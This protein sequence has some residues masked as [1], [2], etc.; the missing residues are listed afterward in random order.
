MSRSHEGSSAKPKR[1]LRA[2]IVGLLVDEDGDIKWNIYQATAILAGVLI[3]IFF[4]LQGPN[5]LQSLAIGLLV[6]GAALAA[7]ILI[8][9]LFGIPRTLQREG[10]NGAAGANSTAEAYGVNTTLE[11]I[12]DWLT[13]IIV[14]VGLLPL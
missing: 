3:L 12:S 6:A 14:G 1:S 13:K 11:Q 2:M 9:F 8:G 4:T 5:P 7:G 10:T